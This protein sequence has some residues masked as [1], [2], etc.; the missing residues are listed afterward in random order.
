MVA[1][2]QLSLQVLPVLGLGQVAAD[3][4]NVKR[5]EFNQVDLA[6]VLDR[7]DELLLVV[8]LVLSA[9]LLSHIWLVVLVH[10]C[11]LDHLLDGFVG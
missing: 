11:V 6:Q 2:G 10:S 3:L 9:P 5:A 4:V 7:V 1:L 8:V